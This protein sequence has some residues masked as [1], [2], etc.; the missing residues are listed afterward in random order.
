RRAL[1]SFP[2]RRSSDLCFPTWCCICSWCWPI[3]CSCGPVLGSCVAWTPRFCGYVGYAWCART[4]SDT[5]PTTP[6][7]DCAV[8]DTTRSDRADV[9]WCGGCVCVIGP[10]RRCC[11]S[12]RPTCPGFVSTAVNIWNT[13]TER[14]GCCCWC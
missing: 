3:R 13:D 4:V 5:C 9:V 6:T 8:V 14:A 11:C 7:G 2:T 12:V 1:L 10:C